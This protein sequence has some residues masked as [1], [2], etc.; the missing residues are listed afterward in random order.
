MRKAVGILMMVF[1]LLTVITGLAE[2]HIHPGRS[3]SH[4]MIAIIL[5]VST[6]V[7]ILINRKAISR[8][9]SGKTAKTGQPT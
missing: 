2:S 3:G 5:I 1:F 6:L 7:H 8:Y 9:F 4:T